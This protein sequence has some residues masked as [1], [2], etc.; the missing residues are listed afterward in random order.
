MTEMLKKWLKNRESELLASGIKTIDIMENG[1]RSM[2]IIQE[3]AVYISDITVRN[4]GFIDIAIL[5]IRTEEY[6][7]CIHFMSKKKAEIEPLLDFYIG[8]MNKGE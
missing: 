2:T 5:S 3:S 8:C 6:V 7:F 1:D 4:D